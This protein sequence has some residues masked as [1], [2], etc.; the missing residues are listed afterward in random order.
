M[1]SQAWRGLWLREGCPLEGREKNRVASDVAVSLDGAM[2]Q[3]VFE[4]IPSN[5]LHYFTVLPRNLLLHFR[6]PGER[7]PC[8]AN[9]ARLPRCSPEN[10]NK[11]TIQS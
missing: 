2:Q 1:G 5:Y 7:D 11:K 10:N 9:G 8:I 3:F 4:L 6:S